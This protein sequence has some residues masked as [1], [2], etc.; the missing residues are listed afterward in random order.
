MSSIGSIDKTQ[1][2]SSFQRKSSPTRYTSSRTQL[3]SITGR[4]QEKSFHLLMSKIEESTSR[5]RKR[6]GTTK[7]KS[8]GRRRTSS[9]LWRRK[10]KSLRNSIWLLSSVDRLIPMVNYHNSLTQTIY[11]KSSS[12]FATISRTSKASRHIA[13]PTK[14]CASTRR[15]CDHLSRAHSCHLM[16]RTPTNRRSKTCPPGSQLL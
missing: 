13:S 2:F 12:I 11:K 9:L 8:A 4:A 15:Q 1:C 14:S 7:Q 6:Q 10:D 5:T 16:L 3:S